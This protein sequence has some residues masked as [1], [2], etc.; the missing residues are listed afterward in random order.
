MTEATSNIAAA[1]EFTYESNPAAADRQKKL[2]FEAV[3]RLI[4]FPE[5]GRAGRIAGTRELAVAGTSY[6]VVYRIRS[7]SIAILA[8][9]HGAR[10]WPPTFKN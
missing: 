4:G 9:L 6:I 2:I 1:Y 5:M 8:V 10:R 7:R 3:G